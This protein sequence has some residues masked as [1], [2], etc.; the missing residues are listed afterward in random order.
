MVPDPPSHKQTLLIV[1]DDAELRVAI[2]AAL[3][4]QFPDTQ[5]RAVAGGTEAWD[6]LRREDVD[7]LLT[8]VVMPGMSGADL[9]RRLQD[10]RP[11]VR[12]LYMSGYTDNTVINQGML[13]PGTPF[14]QKPFTSAALGRN[15]RGA[16]RA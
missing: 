9:A 4:E 2:A 13:P 6:T 1:E 8:D 11:G 7:L 12:V 3:K 14:M 10:V 16:L 15:V 5:V